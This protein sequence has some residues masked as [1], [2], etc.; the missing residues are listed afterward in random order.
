MTLK[1]C[2]RLLEHFEKSGM[3]KEADDMRRHMELKAAKMQRRGLLSAEEAK[4]Y[5]PEKKSAA[6]KGKD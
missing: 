6:K 5:L 4:L 1:N 2:K 3:K